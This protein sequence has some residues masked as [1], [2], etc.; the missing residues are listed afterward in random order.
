MVKAFPLYL[1]VLSCYSL[2][3][4]CSG[5]TFQCPVEITQEMASRGVSMVY[6]QVDDETRDE[7]V[8]ILVQRLT[9]GKR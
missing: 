9:S 2:Y 5:V 3:Q 4:I 7:L 8:S 1:Q 6:E